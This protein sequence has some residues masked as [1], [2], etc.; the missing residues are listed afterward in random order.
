M[1]KN[2]KRACCRGLEVDGWGKFRNFTDY[3][4]DIRLFSILI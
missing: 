3:F 1:L 4:K 2:A